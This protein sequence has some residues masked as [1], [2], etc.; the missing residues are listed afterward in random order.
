MYWSIFC[1]LWWLLEKPFGCTV[2]TLTAKTIQGASLALQSVHHVHGRHRLPFGVFGVGHCVPDDVLQEHLED[3]TSL[4]VDET[5]DSLHTTSARKTTDCGLGD[6]LDIVSKDLPV[7]LGSS[8]AKS[9]TAFATS[10]HLT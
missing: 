9:F 6:T 5:A 10:S 3:S 7:T 2:H 1:R 4:F 8:L